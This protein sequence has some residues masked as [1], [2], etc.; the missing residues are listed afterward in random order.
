MHTIISERYYPLD[1]GTFDCVLVCAC[2]ERFYGVGDMREAK[3]AAAKRH[4]EHRA[5]WLAWAR[6]NLEEAKDERE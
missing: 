6:K 2:G 3:R 1:G 4:E 5:Q